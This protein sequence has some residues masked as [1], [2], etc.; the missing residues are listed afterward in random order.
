MVKGITFKI[1]GRK[2][3]R[4]LYVRICAPNATITY[5][6]Q[7]FFAVSMYLKVECTSLKM[8][9]VDMKLLQSNFHIV[10]ELTRFGTECQIKSSKIYANS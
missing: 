9:P 3:K 1:L 10:K 2:E 7:C 6:M 5:Q 4:L 8:D